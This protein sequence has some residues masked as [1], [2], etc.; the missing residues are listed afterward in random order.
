MFIWKKE[1]KDLP[2]G[3]FVYFLFF[4]PPEYTSC[5]FNIEDVCVCDRVWTLV[6]KGP[7]H[8]ITIDVYDVLMRKRLGVTLGEVQVICALIEWVAQLHVPQMYCDCSAETCSHGLG[9]EYEIRCSNPHLRDLDEL[10]DPS[11]RKA[12]PKVH[13]AVNIDR[14]FIRHI[15]AKRVG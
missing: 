4:V 9:A 2:K 6:D 5:V 15:N 8:L 10:S 11:P 13:I 7:T 1:K 3:T 14:A 12:S